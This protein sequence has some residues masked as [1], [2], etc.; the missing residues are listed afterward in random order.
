MVENGTDRL[1]VDETVLEETDTIV[2]E[3]LESGIQ[4]ISPLLVARLERYGL[5]VGVAFQ[6]AD[7]LLDADED[8]GCSLLPILG[9]EG[10]RARADE[11]EA[12]ALAELEGLGERAE[13]LRALARF[14]VRRKT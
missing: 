5:A 11:L 13:P 9:I 6:V 2:E 14:A 3:L 12:A 8:E 10:A 1:A 4:G 7:D